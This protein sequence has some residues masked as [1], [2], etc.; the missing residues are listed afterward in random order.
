MDIL[1]TQTLALTHRVKRGIAW[2]DET[3]PD[4]RVVINLETLEMQRPWR[5]VLGQIF[6]DHANGYEETNGFGYALRTY[7]GPTWLAQDVWAR[8]HGF[9]HTDYEL[10][11]SVWRGFLA[12]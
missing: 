10:L 12:G 5:C 8:E 2:L 11:D 6:A 9:D 3:V 4:W 7:G 1:T